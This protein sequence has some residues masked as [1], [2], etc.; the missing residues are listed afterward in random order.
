MLLLFTYFLSIQVLT[1][2]ATIAHL[3]FWRCSLLVNLCCLLLL[4]TFTNCLGAVA[5]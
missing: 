4:L 2:A 1:A 5:Y 3:L